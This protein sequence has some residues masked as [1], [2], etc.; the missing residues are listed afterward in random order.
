VKQDPTPASI[1]IDTVNGEA[2]GQFTFNCDTTFTGNPVTVTGSGAGS[3]PP[4][5][6][7]QYH[8]QVDWGD[9][10]VTND[11]GTLTPPSGQD[12]FTYTFTGGPHTYTNS[13]NFIISV[14]L[15][16]Q[17][18]PGN[19]NQADVVATVPVCINLPPVQQEGSDIGVEKTTATVEHHEGDNVDF[20]V[21]A[22]N[23][24]PQD[25]TGVVVSDVVPTGFSYVSDS[26]SQGSYS[27][28]TSDW[29]VGNLANGAA[30]TLT[31]TL[32]V[33][34]G[35]V[36]TSLVNTAKVSYEGDSN[37]ENDTATATVRITKAPCVDGPTWADHVIALVIWQKKVGV[38]K[39]PVIT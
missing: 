24:G 27:S 38:L 15:Y 18:P 5:L 36:G 26:E 4:G 37:S 23:H 3:A 25:A 12:N 17:Q 6:I 13:G 32:K 19:D 16:H 1:Q 10:N 2:S 22:T 21:T 31:I 14:K 7:E 29:T 28:G 34:S 33:D 20:T 8:V 11:L 39:S 30:A 35:T 9:T